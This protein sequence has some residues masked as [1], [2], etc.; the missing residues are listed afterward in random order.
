MNITSR[1]SVRTKS[2]TCYDE[3]A[4]IFACLMLILL[5][6]NFSLSFKF[7]CTHRFKARRKSVRRAQLNNYMT[8]VRF[9]QRYV[10]VV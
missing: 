4:H 8:A 10:S 6:P 7:F 5:A 3:T 2:E 9:G 1:K